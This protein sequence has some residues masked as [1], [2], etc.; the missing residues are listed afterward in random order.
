MNQNI[1]YPDFFELVNRRYSCRNFSDAPVSRDVINAVLETARVAPSACNR[2]PYKFLVIDSPELCKVVYGCY[3]RSW[4]CTTSTFIIAVGNHNE[5]WHRDYDDKDATDID[6]AIA[7]EH[8][9]LAATS[10]KLATCWVC[11]F[12]KSILIKGLDIPEGWEPIVVI[13]IGYPAD[14]EPE[15]TRKQ[16]E[17]IVKWGKF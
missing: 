14:S 4:I 11:N 5:A 16:I 15:K 2:Q 6:V 9:C 17:D 8:I 10:L 1:D 13:P 3:N 7:V 12:Q